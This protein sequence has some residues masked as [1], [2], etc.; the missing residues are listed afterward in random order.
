MARHV[1]QIVAALLAWLATP[2]MIIAQPRVDTLGDPLPAGAI[3]RV[4]TT[5]MRH[6]SLPGRYCWGISCITWSSDG[7]MLATTSHTAGS[8]GVDVRLWEASTGKPLRRLE[9]NTRYG[10]S[11]ARFSPDN[12]MLAAAAGSRIVLWDTAT[13]K[14][15]GQLIGHQDVLDSLVFQNGGQTL[16]SISRDGAVQ[17][18][19]VA[20]RQTL[21][22]WQLPT[23]DF[24]Q[25]D[26]GKPVLLRGI[27][28]TCF[29][30]DGT[31]LAVAK[32]W[33]TESKKPLGAN[34]AVVYDLKTKKEIW[35]DATDN[36]FYHFAFSH[37]GK[38]LAASRA[39]IVD[40]LDIATHRLRR[41]PQWLYPSGMDFALDD[42]TLALTVNGGVVFWSPVK[43]SVR[44]IDVPLRGGGYNHFG[45]GPAFSPDGKKLAIDRGRSFQVIDV[46]T[47]KVGLAWPSYDEGFDSLTF[48][49]DGRTLFES[50][51]D[52]AIDTT[53]WRPRSVPAVPREDWQCVSAERTLCVARD[54]EHP[55]TLFDMKTGGVVAR[56]TAPPRKLGRHDGFFSP[57]AKLYVRRDLECNGTE[58][59]TLF[60]IPSAQQRFSLSF[61]NG[62]LEWSFSADDSRV[63]CFDRSA[64]WI[65]VYETATGKLLQQID[66]LDSGDRKV[67]LALSP[68]GNL[69]AV[70]SEGLGGVHIWDVRTGTCGRRLVHKQEAK[71]GH[72]CLA[73]SADK[74]MLAVGGLDNSVRL[75]E[76]AS[77]QVRREF[78]GHEAP[79]CCLAFS[80]DGRIL[81]TGSEDTTIMAWNTDVDK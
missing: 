24:K 60:A 51:T 58:T 80:S 64:G 20:G 44:E 28:N 34:L 71:G 48:S 75:W 14:E 12:K 81:A 8:V 55:D 63:A 65:R 31:T 45:T 52:L 19:D 41:A 10:P 15:L 18:W 38:C 42:K 17:W 23:N 30:A 11:F 46:A 37:D 22:T 36:V 66:P 1:L 76:V 3:A 78:C 32:W 39:G 77:A 21:R 40:V 59:Y 35:R 5:R 61:E 33:T 9:N 70:W 69:L 26:N 27:E 47:G 25:T 56:F 79:A 49:A 50:H 74:R 73:W 16:V 13:G 62:A 54:G 53:S 4:G 2:P 29:S 43:N 57:R 6:C 68:N 72:A 67:S 7:T